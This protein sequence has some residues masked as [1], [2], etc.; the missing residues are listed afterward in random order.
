VHEVLQLTSLPF[1]PCVQNRFDFV[2]F[3]IIDDRR[4]SCKGR[5]VCFRFL[6]WQEEVYVEDVMDLH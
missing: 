2:F 3:L 6:I 5:A 1:T 4:R